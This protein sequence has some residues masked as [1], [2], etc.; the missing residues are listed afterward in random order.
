MLTHLSTRKQAVEMARRI[1]VQ[2]GGVRT[3]M[4]ARRSQVQKGAVGM[5]PHQS[6]RPWGILG[7]VGSCMHMVHKLSQVHT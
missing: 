7:F 1:Q 5:A 6:Q 4:T 3:S 2:K